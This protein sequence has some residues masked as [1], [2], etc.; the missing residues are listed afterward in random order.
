M[1]LLFD[2]SNSSLTSRTFRIDEGK[3]V[4]IVAIGMQPGDYITFEAIHLIASAPPIACGCY[5]TEAEMPYIAGVQELKC[6]ACLSETLRPVRL[7][8]RNPSVVLDSPQDTL[9][10]AVYHGTG[11]DAH[12][13][14]VWYDETNTPDL[15]D[16]MRGCPPVCCEDEPQTWM[17][18]GIYRCVG[19]NVELQEISN[20]GNLRWV[21]C[22][23][24]VWTPTGN[25]RCDDTQ[26]Y[27]EEVNQCGHKRWT[28]LE[29]IN[30]LQTG[31][32]RCTDTV[33]Q[34]QEVNQC[35]DLRWVDGEPI[36]W[37]DTGA[38]RCVPDNETLTEIEQRNQCGDTR[39][40]DG[41]DQEWTATGAQRCSDTNVEVQEVNQCG[42]LRWVEGEELVWTYT[43]QQ[44]CVPGSETA[45]ELEQRNQCGETR[46][47]AGPDQDWE[48]TGA[49]RCRAGNVER[50]QRNQCGLSRWVILEPVA[51]VATGLR[52]CSDAGVLVQ[53]I[54]QCSQ[55]RWT[56]TGA[57]T[58]RVTGLLHCQNGTYFQQEV[59][60]CGRMRWTDTGI[61]CG[62]E[63]DSMH[64]IV[65]LDVSPSTGEAGVPFCWTV[66]LDAP[67]SG[68]DLTLV[69]VLSG[70][71]QTLRGYADPSVTIPVGATSGFMCV[72]TDTGTPGDAPR[73]LC[74][75]IAVNPRI[76]N[77]PAPVC[78]TVTS[79]AEGASTHSASLSVAPGSAAEGSVF[80]FTVTLDAPV[81]V[82][83]L[84]V[85]VVL[86][87]DEQAAHGYL[88]P[89]S[90]TIPI[91]SS[92]GNF[93]VTTVNDAAGGPDTTLT[94]TIQPNVRL[95]SIPVPSASA[96]VTPNAASEDPMLP[97]PGEIGGG[98][99]VD[100]PSPT[101]TTFYVQVD[102]DG[103]IYWRTP[104]GPGVDDFGWLPGGADPTDYEVMVTGSAS[105]GGVTYVGDTR[106]VWL[107][108]TSTRTYEWR[109]S[110][111]GN[112]TNLTGGSVALRK[113]GDPG[114]EVSTPI[115][116]TFLGASVD[117]P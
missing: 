25:E 41:P 11:V 9:L 67:V 38:L 8:D 94:G 7:T 82:S 117:C 110:G 61:A 10:R 47:V 86:S 62:G 5:I 48:E 66:T 27:F 22:G 35:G 115:G 15:T 51:W 43:G 54:N 71:E 6:P 31:V 50:E 108:L 37:V 46:W 45:T 116:D 20:C 28:V 109:V 113:I 95:T 97:P 89:R 2:P 18:N 32:Q 104:F 96:T 64:M 30:W 16:T 88:S 39:W 107:P 80:T 13:V 52:Q 76:T 17:P 26:H 91:G 105:G 100:R 74:L 87:G 40:I 72:T 19:G 70:A 33:V 60:E 85:S 73:D 106:G 29:P 42:L 78:A 49:Q 69:G 101:F 23:T 24:I 84:I 103:L 114:S 21:I 99:V 79:P 111:A 75:D 77:D 4:T 112:S 36:E 57:V 12:T 1:K 3:Q 102:M 14:T 44:R 56:N 83:D 59:D 81:A 63:P 58:W 90:V 65:A 68:A 93:T 34:H 53:E 55:L 92:T 98:C